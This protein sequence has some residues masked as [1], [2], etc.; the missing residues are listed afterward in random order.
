MLPA[1]DP[2]YRDTLA[3]ALAEGG[4]FEEA[5]QVQAEVVSDLR[6]AGVSPQT[7]AGVERRLE[8]YRA[9]VGVRDPEPPGS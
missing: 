8:A 1:P 9:G 2:G 3:A 5:V 7:I 4:R 6:K